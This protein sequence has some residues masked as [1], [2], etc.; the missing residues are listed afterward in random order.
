[1]A[2]N[3]YSYQPQV[4]YD[5]LLIIENLDYV[6]QSSLVLYFIYMY[7]IETGICYPLTHTTPLIYLASVQNATQ[8]TYLYTKLCSV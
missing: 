1:M 5:H 3:A 8:I 7:T 6:F 4:K 2:V